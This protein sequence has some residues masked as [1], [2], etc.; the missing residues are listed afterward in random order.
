MSERLPQGIREIAA[1]QV[2]RLADVVAA[3]SEIGRA[4]V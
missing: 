3:L 2:E 1:G 4:H